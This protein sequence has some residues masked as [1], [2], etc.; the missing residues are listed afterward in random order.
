MN[1]VCDLLVVYSN[2]VEPKIKQE[3]TEFVEQ[4]M[5]CLPR[6]RTTSQ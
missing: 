1:I 3:K 4:L 5:H 2:Q 6:R